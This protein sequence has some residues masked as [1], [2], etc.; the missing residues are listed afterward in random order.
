MRN[1]TFR[2]PVETRASELLAE[3]FV[4]MMSA[5][6]LC[7]LVHDTHHE[8]IVWANPAACNTLGLTTEDMGARPSDLVS[9]SARQYMTSVGQGSLQEALDRGTCQ[10]EWRHQSPTGRDVSTDGL[11]VRVELATGPAV[12]VQFRDFE[13]DQQIEDALRV[14]ASYV[15]TLSRHTAAGLLVLALDGTVLHA[16]DRALMQFDGRPRSEMVG[17]PITRF[18]Q[19]PAAIDD[20][21]A[22][23][24]WAHALEEADPIG[25]IQ[26]RLL[27]PGVGSTWLGGMVERV[28]TPGSDRLVLTV[29]D[30]SDLVEDQRRRAL[31]LQHE[32][33]LARYNVMGDMAMAIA[34]ELGQ[35]LAAAGNF[36]AGARARISAL[37]S[38]GTFPTLPAEQVEYGLESAHRQIDRSSTIVAALRTFVGHLE[39][40]EQTVDLNDVIAEC[41][42]FVRLRAAPADVVVDVELSDIPVLVRCER[43]LTGQVVLNLCSN[44]IDELAE[45][46]P[47]RRKVIIS[48]RLQHSFG[49]VLVDDRGRGITRDPFAESFT[50]K[51]HGSGIGLALS[52]R[53]I[54][55][56]HGTIWAER[57][58]DEG[59]RFGFSLP[60]A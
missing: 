25:S 37:E 27:G 13:R 34:H 41:L 21:G 30:I 56:Q 19:I 50:S 8:H 33:Y 24:G 20:P 7:V 17:A 47:E 5:S 57:R 43:V 44:A 23:Q 60:T 9:E 32:N 11:A 18:C 45:C 3:D 36:L 39:H 58:Q 40:V 16:T 10:I 53:I 1:R 31:E 28:T 15:E 59:S 38:A 48:T 14:T 42:Y 22:S 51:S 4:T 26:L 29:H 52:H 49:E 46:A 2:E 35:P 54:T 6:S 12:M 55:R